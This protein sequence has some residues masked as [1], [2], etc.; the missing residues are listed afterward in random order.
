MR[1]LRRCLVAC[2][3]SAALLAVALLSAAPAGAAIAVTLPGDESPHPATSMEWWYFTGHLTGT[4]PLGQVHQYGFELTFIRTN[5]LGLEPLSAAYD[6][7]FAITDLTRGTFKSNML[8]I[9]IQPDTVVPDGGFNN[10]VDGWNMNGKSG[11]NHISAAFADASYAI[12]LNLNQSTPAAL[13]GTGGL[14]PYA[15]FGTSYYYSETNLKASGTLIDHG[16]PITVTG[17]GWQDHQWGNFTGTGGWTWFSV[18]LANGTQYMLYFLHDAS[19]NIVQKAGTLVNA[20]GSTV[21]LAPSAMT[22][23]PLGTWTSPNTGIT[24]PQNWVVT[25]PGGSLNVTALE[26]NQELY[27]PFVGTGYWEGDSSVTGTINGASVTGQGYA[28][29]T[30]TYTLPI[31]ISSI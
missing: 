7:Q 15:P 1:R 5:S 21:S 2:A 3:L 19:G 27:V 13:H 25:V 9:S 29:I 28:E 23:T 6:G 10:T 30:P 20:D 4:D 17:I 31:S 22:D 11:Q 8:A 12:S 14:I 24:Y 16:I 26:A 18:Q